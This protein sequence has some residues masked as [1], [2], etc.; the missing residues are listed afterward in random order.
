M[1]VGVQLSPGSQVITV[2]AVPPGLTTTAV[3]S[4]PARGSEYDGPNCGSSGPRRSTPPNPVMVQG[5]SEVLRQTMVVS[6]WLSP[7]V[8]PTDARTV[9]LVQRATSPASDDDVC[10]VGCCAAVVGGV[11]SAAGASDGA[12]PPPHPATSSPADSSPIRSGVR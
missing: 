10:S 12:A 9:L 7:R 2:C 4:S 1:S 8:V 6:F 5:A 11:D 3:G